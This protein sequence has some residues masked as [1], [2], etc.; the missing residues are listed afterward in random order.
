[1]NHKDKIFKV[2]TETLDIIN[3]CQW[4]NYYAIAETSVCFM[5]FCTSKPAIYQ[6]G[7]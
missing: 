1:M 7:M 5:I 6:S 2:Q 4:V 3:S